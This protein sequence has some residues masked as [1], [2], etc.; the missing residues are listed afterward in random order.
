MLQEYQNLLSQQPDQDQARRMLKIL[1]FTIASALNALPPTEENRLARCIL[2]AGTMAALYEK[3]GNVASEEDFLTA[4]R[5]LRSRDA[6]TH[7]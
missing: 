7:T 4:L 1:T 5:E 6:L 3:V 2:D